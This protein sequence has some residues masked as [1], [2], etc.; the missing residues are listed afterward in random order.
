MK[1]KKW[2][3]LSFFL[4]FVHSG[5]GQKEIVDDKKF[6]EDEAPVEMKVYTDIRNLIAQKKS[7]N[8]VYATITCTFPGG[9]LVDGQVRI[10][11]RG[12]FRKENCR[13]SSLTFDFN[14]KEFPAF[15]KLGTLKLVGGCGT[16]ERDEQYVLKEYLVYKIYNLLTDLS[17]R[18]RLMH[19]NYNDTK[20]K[21]KPYTQYAFFIEDIDDLAKRNKCRKKEEV[22]FSHHHL[23]REQAFFVYLF[24]YMIGNTDWS[25]PFYHNIKLVVDRKDTFS[26]PYPIAYDFDMTG[27]V[28]PPYGT[29]NQEL[30][31]EKLTDRLYRGYQRSIEEVDATV[32]IFCEREEAIYSLIRN[33]SLLSPKNRN[34][35]LAFLGDFF[36]QVK[37]KKRL[38]DICVDNAL[39][40]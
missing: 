19:V 34:E 28:N 12:H 20:G 18:V 26:R 4:Y 36:T 7:L 32:K 8:Y 35:M 24:Q 9:K 39:K 33:F 40:N 16:S 30:G 21:A 23:D 3:V 29:G 22:K 1:S 27:L 17:F 10:K 25:M 6:F 13:L 2:V 31:L 37:N 14:N 15:S 5:F 38:K 11:P